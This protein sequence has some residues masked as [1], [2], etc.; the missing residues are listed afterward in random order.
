MERRNLSQILLD[1]KLAQFGDSFVNF[2]YSLA[3]TRNK[4]IPVGTKVSD[5]ILASAA[6]KAGIRKLLP[7]RTSRGDVSNA[8][9]AL[10]VYAWLRHHMTIDEASAI[11]EEQMDSPSDAFA[12][13]SKKILEKLID[14]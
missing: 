6:Q 9:E 5:K 4:G 1:R 12:A 10:V 8:V 11:L 7:K 2:V 3:L 13:L 14:E